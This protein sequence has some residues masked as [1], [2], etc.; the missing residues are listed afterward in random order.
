[1][2]V[3]AVTLLPLF[4]CLVSC[5][6]SSGDKKRHTV[7][8][9]R[10]EPIDGGY[11][12]STSTDSTRADSS[13]CIIRRKATVLVI[14]FWYGKV[15]G[16]APHDLESVASR[17]TSRFREEAGLLGLSTVQHRMYAEGTE[18]IAPFSNLVMNGEF[19][20][21][22]CLANIGRWFSADWVVFGVLAWSSQTH[23]IEAFVVESRDPTNHRRI[24]FGIGPYDNGSREIHLAWTRLVKISQ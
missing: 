7:V 14:D 11:G 5:N 12:G 17:V 15:S 22:S 2:D 1:M 20:N 24:S 6:C 23:K 4:L 3:G 9:V 16:T 21:T 10:Q 8:A 13:A 18:C 19:D